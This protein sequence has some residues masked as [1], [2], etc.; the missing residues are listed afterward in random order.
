M[1]KNAYKLTD[2][3]IDILK[4]VNVIEEIEYNKVNYKLREIIT[5]DSFCSTKRPFLVFG[6]AKSGD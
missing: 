3:A 4:Y 2:I 5:K 1:L 6:I